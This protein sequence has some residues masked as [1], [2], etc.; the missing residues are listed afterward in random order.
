[1]TST[2]GELRSDSLKSIAYKAA[3]GYSS[4]HFRILHLDLHAVMLLK[5]RGPVA[6]SLV[7]ELPFPL[8]YPSDIE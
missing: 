5:Q 6:W 2:A 1:M 4:R 3:A 8:R 7:D